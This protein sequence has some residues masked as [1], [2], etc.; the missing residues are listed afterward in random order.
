MNHELVVEPTHLKHMREA[1]WVHLPPIFGLKMTNHRNHH[2]LDHK[3]IP[4]NSIWVFPKVGAP[5]NGWFIM[6][7]PIKMDDLGVP[8]F[9]EPPIYHLTTKTSGISPF[10]PS[11]SRVEG[12]KTPPH[13]ALVQA[14]YHKLAP[15]GQTSYL[16]SLK[17]G[18]ENLTNGH[19]YCIMC[20]YS[21]AEI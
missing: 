8:L 6:E 5:Q 17:K 19:G 11:P 9:L 3:Y 7:N 1:K 20:V 2:H 12:T 10:S 16:C 13:L 15:I 4:T 18:E 21:Y 14:G